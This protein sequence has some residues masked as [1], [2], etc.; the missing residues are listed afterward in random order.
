MSEK[1]GSGSLCTKLVPAA[2]KGVLV[3]A[4]TSSGGA[5]GSAPTYNFDRLVDISKVVTRNLNK[6]V[7]VNYYPIEEARRSNMRHRPIGIEPPRAA[8]RNR[9]A[10]TIRDAQRRK[11]LIRDAADEF[12]AHAVPRIFSRLMQRH[13]DAA[14]EECDAK[15]QTG[16]PSPG[17]RHGMDHSRHALK[18]KIPLIRTASETFHI[19][20]SSPSSGPSSPF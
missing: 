3:C 12:P 11:R 16:E 15:R 14:F 13:G 4:P 9:L 1:K 7:D 19:D 5:A 17:N 8:Q 18:R 20:G 6:V 10:E 2:V